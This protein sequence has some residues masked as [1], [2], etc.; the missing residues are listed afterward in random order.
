VTHNPLQK[1]EIDKNLPVTRA[2][3]PGYFS[4]FFMK[5]QQQQKIKIRN[6]IFTVVV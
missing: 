2:A 4:L 6:R 3:C 1:C 5:Q